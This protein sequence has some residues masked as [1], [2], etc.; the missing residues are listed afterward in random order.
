LSQ[1]TCPS[2]LSLFLPNPPSYP[3]FL[4]FVLIFPHYSLSFAI[5]KLCMSPSIFSPTSSHFLIWF[6]SVSNFGPKH[7]RFLL[8]GIVPLYSISN[9]L[10]RLA[11]TE[12]PAQSP[13][14][15]SSSSAC[16]HA[17]SSCGSGVSYFWP[18]W[19]QSTRGPSYL[20]FQLHS[21]PARRPWN[22]QDPVW[23]SHPES[24]AALRISRSRALAAKRVIGK[25]DPGSRTSQNEFQRKPPHSGL[26]PD[27]AR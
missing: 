9:F 22:P 23:F 24:G 6:T 3:I 20:P 10:F 19:F 8:I 21:G 14:T 27:G 7:S 25:L 16:Q 18:E 26:W 15:C 1:P 13:T 4:T 12:P 5:K 11:P 17:S 2:I